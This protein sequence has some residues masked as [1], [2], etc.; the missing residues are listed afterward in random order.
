[1]TSAATVLAGKDAGRAGPSAGRPGA[2]ASA[3]LAGR[4]DRGGSR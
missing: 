3:A 1:M 2:P 4:R